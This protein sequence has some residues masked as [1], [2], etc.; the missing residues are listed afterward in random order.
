VFGGGVEVGLGLRDVGGVIDWGGVGWGGLGGG[1]GGGGG[2]GRAGAPPFKGQA[3]K[4]L[5]YC[6]VCTCT[7]GIL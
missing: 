6:P 2:G 4:V 3:C 7:S 5:G 1:G